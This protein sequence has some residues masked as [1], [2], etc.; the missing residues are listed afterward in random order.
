VGNKLNKIEKN[1]RNI[2]I[3]GPAF[4]HYERVKLPDFENPHDLRFH[5]PITNPLSREQDVIEKKEIQAL[6]RFSMDQVGPFALHD[7]RG[8]FFLEIK[9]RDHL[10]NEFLSKQAKSSKGKKFKNKGEGTNLISKAAHDFFNLFSV[11]GESLLLVE[12]L[13][14]T[15]DLLQGPFQRLPLLVI[16]TV[17]DHLLEEEWVFHHPL[18]G[19]QQKARQVQV[20]ATRIPLQ[21]LDVVVDR[22]LLTLS[23]QQIRCPCVVHKVP[24][25]SLENLGL[26][27]AE[28]KSGKEGRKEESEK[29]GFGGH[30]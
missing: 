2:T 21:Y 18:N 15:L 22:F 4:I 13:H 29:R 24:T 16:F 9:C 17:F 5:L 30:T 11:L 28:Q 23:D 8:V 14:H 26:I 7:E 6:F 1:Q 3:L 27:T 10:T 20:A 19:F 25:V 12:L